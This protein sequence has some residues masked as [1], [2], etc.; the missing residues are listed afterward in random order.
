MSRAKSKKTTPPIKPKPSDD[1]LDARLILY[2]RGGKEYFRL[3]FAF[4]RRHWVYREYLKFANGVDLDNPDS[5]CKPNI[6]EAK[7]LLDGKYSKGLH[8]CEE[9][10]F[11]AAEV[12]GELSDKDIKRLGGYDEKASE[13][14]K[15]EYWWK[16]YREPDEKDRKE[17][18]RVYQEIAD[19]F[20]GALLSPEH[21]LG[22][23]LALTRSIRSGHCSDDDLRRQFAQTLGRFWLFDPLAAAP[24][25]TFKRLMEQT[26]QLREERQRQVKAEKRF[27]PLDLRYTLRVWDARKKG[28]RT[29]AQVIRESAAEEL[30][31]LAAEA[32]SPQLARR[33][34]K[35]EKDFEYRHQSAY[36]LPYGEK[37]KQAELISKNCMLYGI[38]PNPTSSP[39]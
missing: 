4:A 8:L 23:I 38:F 28:N 17:A 35:L 36:H 3:W 6:D 13:E 7:R 1:P 29:W 34:K 39:P 26:R 22:R 12:M 9:M 11:F 5:D 21:L 18:V 32:K 19:S 25:E 33:R 24:R 30:K 37:V 16:R 10:G 2:G 27:R 15:F 20:Q 31:A 14:A